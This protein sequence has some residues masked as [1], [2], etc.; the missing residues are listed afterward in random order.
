MLGQADIYKGYN[1][2][3]EMGD[4]IRLRADEVVQAV[5]GVSIDEAVA[6]PPGSLDTIGRDK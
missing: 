2:R 5:D 4:G 1:P 3:I 6:C